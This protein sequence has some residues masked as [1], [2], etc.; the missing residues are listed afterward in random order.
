[1]CAD[2][3]VGGFLLSGGMAKVRESDEQLCRLAQAGDQ[4]ARDRLAARYINT[5]GLRTSGYMP[6]F[7]AGVLDCEDLGQEGFI[8]LLG[9]ING[10]DESFGASFH[11]FAVLNIDRRMA[12]AVKAAC[13]KKQVPPSA[14]VGLDSVAD[15]SDPEGAVIA[16]DELERVSRRINDM[17]SEKERRVLS[18]YLAGYSYADIAERLSCSKKSVENALGRVRRKLGGA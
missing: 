6:A 17:T 10:Y 11:T 16:R 7:G 15:K 18:L 8:G 9:A 14:R 4:S 2:M 1:M 12:D 3:H 5:V 13:R